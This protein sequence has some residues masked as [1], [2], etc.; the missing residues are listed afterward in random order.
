MKSF[1]PRS[2]RSPSSS[3]KVDLINFQVSSDPPVEPMSLPVSTWSDAFESVKK[4]RQWNPVELPSKVPTVTTSS[5]IHG[6]NPPLCFVPTNCLWTI[7][8]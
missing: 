7:N 2:S 1:S 4:E 5:S 3:P 6:K 8:R